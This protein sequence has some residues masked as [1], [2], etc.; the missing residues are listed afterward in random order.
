MVDIAGTLGQGSWWGHS[1]S[2]VPPLCG[3]KLDFLGTLRGHV[4]VPLGPY[5]AWL[6]YVTGGL[7]YSQVKGM[8][9]M[10]CESCP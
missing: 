10:W 8:L 3:T 6:P 9:G 5:G 1:K 4:G 7:A 2:G